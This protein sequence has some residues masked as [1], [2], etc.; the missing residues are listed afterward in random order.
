[1][2][3][4]KA[5]LNTFIEETMAFVNRIRADRCRAPS[6]NRTANHR[7]IGRCLSVKR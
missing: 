1:M 4:L 5:S 3:N 7:W 6:W 2:L